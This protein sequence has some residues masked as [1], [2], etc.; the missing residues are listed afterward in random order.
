MD[1]AEIIELFFARDERA[2][3]ETDRK[4]GRLCFRIAENLL[5]SKNDSDEC[6]NDT[7]FAVW[8]RIPPVR[9]YNFTAFICR[10]TRN[11]SQNSEK[12]FRTTALPRVSGTKKPE[13]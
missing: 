4:Y 10:I 1:D 3:A 9:P 7:Y 5:H 11:P 6:V 8:N 2:I 12:P 13:G